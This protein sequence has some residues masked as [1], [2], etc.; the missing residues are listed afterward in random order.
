MTERP[1]AILF[2]LDGTLVDTI[3]LI[4]QSMEF[5]FAEFTGVR[6]TREQWLRGLGIPLR[7]QITEHARSSEELDVLIARYRLFQGEHHDAMTTAYPG[8]AN[9]LNALSGRGHPMG[10]VTSKYFAT[11]KKAL[12]HTGIDAHISVVI[13]ADSTPNQK[14]HPEPVLTAIAQLKTEPARALFV[15]DSPHDIAAGN[16]A[17][18]ATVAATWGPFPRADLEAAHPTHWLASIEALPD[19][20]NRV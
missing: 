3:E 19:L 20:V 13:G 4:M 2:D 1:I 5:A 6:P 11:A 15:G 16:A 14:P 9:V 7:K 8:V 18:V 12:V 10:L 17:G